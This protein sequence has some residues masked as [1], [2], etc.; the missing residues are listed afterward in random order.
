LS[1][2]DFGGPEEG[3]GIRLKNQ[4]T[5]REA[6]E[7]RAAP[8]MKTVNRIFAFILRLVLVLGICGFGVFLF[9]YFYKN[10][11]KKATLP[12]GWLM[13]GHDQPRMESPEA[14]LE[15]AQALYGEGQIR[16]AWGF[17]LAALIQ[18]WSRYRALAFPPDATEYDC[19]ALVRAEAA[20]TGP[21]GT[22][23]EAENFASA[24]GRWVA[25]AYGGRM[26][27]AGSFEETLAFCRSLG[28]PVSEK[29]GGFPANSPEAGGE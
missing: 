23:R 24:V 2:R 3:W 21:A 18:A 28:P 19:L 15:K 7:R 4:E 17:C 26:P 5:E 12:G 6:P 10:R 11:G 20:R 9:R 25:L 27:P 16:R 8:W 29:T 14:L 13:G 1:S 22:A